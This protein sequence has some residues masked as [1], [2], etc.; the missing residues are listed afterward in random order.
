MKWTELER[1]DLGQVP[2]R[3]KLNEKG[4]QNKY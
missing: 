1:R 2:L 4:K 3:V